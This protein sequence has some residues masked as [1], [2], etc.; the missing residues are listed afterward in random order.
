MTG[1][2]IHIFTDGGSRGN[3]GPSACA[4]VA[5]SDPGGSG[6]TGGRRLREMSGY[7]G[8]CTNNEAEYSALIM[9]V[10]WA[11]SRGFSHIVLHSDSELV[12]RQL[13]G[14]YRVRSVVL[15]PLHE[16]V[17]KML[18]GRKW[19]IVHHRRS[20]PWIALCDELVNNE[21]DTRP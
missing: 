21:L 17:L 8:R 5:V 15:K 11:D 18:S 6:W 10:E 7:L 9:A 19:D 20:H 1:G 3:P 4:F 12:V 14:E 2:A 13:R 16:R